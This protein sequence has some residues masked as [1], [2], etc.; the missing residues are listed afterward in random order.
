[1]L[2]SLL[3]FLA[4]GCAR[5]EPKNL[6]NISIERPVRSNGLIVA[7]K[8]FTKNDCKRYLDRDVISKGYQPVQLFIE[9]TTDA[10]YRF[11]TSLVTLPTVP[12]E[13]VSKKLHTSTVGRIAGYGAAALLASPLFAVPAVV[14]GFKSVKANESL[15]EDFVMKGAHD[16]VIAP[17]TYANMVLFVPVK[18][19]QESFTLS[20]IEENTDKVV[21]IVASTR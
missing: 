18:D 4:I 11:L 1:M 16:C 14:D 15:D 5:Y 7:A 20:L 2:F 6:A 10:S 12:P 3:T 9:N 17:H 13:E 21:K 19:F 8:A